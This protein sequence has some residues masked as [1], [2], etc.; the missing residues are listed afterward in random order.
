[1]IHEIGQDLLAQFQAR[2]VPIPVVDGPEHRPTTTFAR[3]RVVIEHDFSADEINAPRGARQLTVTNG[4][5]PVRY[6]VLTGVKITIYAKATRAGAMYW[7]HVRRAEQIR[8]QILCCLYVIQ[9]VRQNVCSFKSGKFIYPKDLED[10]ETPGGAA[11]ELFL[12]FDRA[13]FD[14]NW[15]GT[16]AKVITVTPTMLGGAITFA[17]G[18]PSTITRSF[19]S[20][21]ADGFAVGQFVIVTGSTSNNGTFGPITVLTPTVMTFASGLV[22]EGPDTGATITGTGIVINTVAKANGE[23]I[24]PNIPS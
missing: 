20:F 7:E 14:Q 13:A 3:E 12:T 23:T 16:T 21:A 1:M 24:V 18:P 5:A 11:Y 19:G 2:A 4:Q 8:D 10:S 6:N 15:D 9:K 17:A 22:N